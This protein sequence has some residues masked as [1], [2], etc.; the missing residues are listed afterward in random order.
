MNKPILSVASKS[1]VYVS[2][3]L[4]S[5]ILIITISEL[6]FGKG[7][8]LSSNM[9]YREVARIYYRV[10]GNY[11]CSLNRDTDSKYYRLGSRMLDKSNEIWCLEDKNIDLSIITPEEKKFLISKS[12]RELERSRLVM[13]KSLTLTKFALAGSL[14]S[15]LLTIPLGFVILPLF[16]SGC[17]L[18]LIGSSLH[19]N[20]QISDVSSFGERLTGGQDVKLTFW[21]RIN[22][23]RFVDGVSLINAGSSI[24][25]SRLCQ[26]IGL[27][28]NATGSWLV[29]GTVAGG[30]LPLVER[31]GVFHQWVGHIPIV[32]LAINDIVSDGATNGTVLL[33]GAT[34]K[35]DSFMR[36]LFPTAKYHNLFYEK[37]YKIQA[38][39]QPLTEE[40][41]PLLNAK[42]KSFCDGDVLKWV[43]D[44]SASIDCRCHGR[45]YTQVGPDTA[46]YMPCEDIKVN[47]IDA[48]SDM[49]QLRQAIIKHC[50]NSD[51]FADL[52]GGLVEEDKKAIIGTAADRRLNQVAKAKPDM[53]I[54]FTSDM[55][56]VA[57][58]PNAVVTEGFFQPVAKKAKDVVE[59][60]FDGVNRFAPTPSIP[61]NHSNHS[62]NNIRINLMRIKPVKQGISTVKERVDLVD[63]GGIFERGARL[64][65]D[66]VKNGTPK[67]YVFSPPKIEVVK[68]IVPAA[69]EVIKEGTSETVRN[70]IHLG[71]GFAFGKIAAK[72]KINFG[73]RFF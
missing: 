26:K 68:N 64:L 38:E 19:F 47:C 34:Q 16:S 61:I 43:R 57:T 70:V 36:P 32:G 14:L 4:A 72:K 8:G 73:P 27:C 10:L 42:M 30:L 2:S 71:D 12:R 59:V 9:V 20:S 60:V 48:I 39:F 31:G 44:V 22:I 54:K 21:Q 13:K 28:V 67:D 37:Y 17:G 23:K 33:I 15:Y 29:L 62:N 50:T 45:L 1:V 66:V 65:P 25:R 18:F 41:L 49:E 56:H 7:G 5:L 69:P 40:N 58:A 53:K 11:L 24:K 63:L 55:F 6:F 35:L 52:A 3:Y 46:T 51:V